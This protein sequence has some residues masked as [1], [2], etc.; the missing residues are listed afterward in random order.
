MTTRTALIA[1]ALAAMLTTTPAHS[2]NW[3]FMDYSPVR[4]FTDAD[5]ALF[6]LTARGLLEKAPDGETRTWENPDTGNQG[7]IKA[8]STYKDDVGLKCRQVKVR[9]ATRRGLT[10]E[11]TVHV[12]KRP[13]GNWQLREPPEPRR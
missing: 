8:I 12:C 7:A 13:K 9:N 11:A 1:A 5:W 10:G 3:R 2:V 6:R 4:F